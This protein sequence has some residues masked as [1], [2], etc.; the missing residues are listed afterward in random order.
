MRCGWHAFSCDMYKGFELSSG[1]LCTDYS[2][3]RDSLTDCSQDRC[4][5]SNSGS[6]YRGFE[7]SSGPICT[8]DSG[9][10]D[11]LTDCSQDRFAMSKCGSQRVPPSPRSVSTKHV[12]CVY[13]GLPLRGLACSCGSVEACRS[14]G[15]RVCTVPSLT[16]TDVN[17][18]LPV[19][20]ESG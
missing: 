10:R 17:R 9:S 3:S 4:A 19:R 6:Q 13:S 7:L 14:E 8:D 1:P 11:S 18:S 16:S 5:T 15:S 12:P 20:Q 2:G